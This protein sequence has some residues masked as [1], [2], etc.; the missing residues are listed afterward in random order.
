MVYSLSGVL[1]S[2]NPARAGMILV[3]TALRA[4]GACKPRACGDDP[5]AVVF[6]VGP[7]S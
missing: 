3:F 7:M 5:H 2:V 4:S 1:V 6:C